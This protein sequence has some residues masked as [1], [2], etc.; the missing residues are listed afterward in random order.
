MNKLSLFLP[1]YN[2][3]QCLQENIFKLDN[4]LKTQKLKYEIFI[5]DDNSNDGSFK[6]GRKLARENQNIIYL[7]YKNGPSRRENLGLS[8]KKA[9]G[10]ILGF[11]DIHFDVS[12]TNIPRAIKYI[13]E[14][15]DFVVGSKYLKKSEYSRPAY[16]NILSKLYNYAIKKILGSPFADHNCGFKFFRQEALFKVL[17]KMGYDKS[18]KRGWFWDAEMLVRANSLGMKIYEMPVTYINN[19]NKTSVRV[20]RD[21]KAIRSMFLLRKGLK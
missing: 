21:I 15:N 13:E 18:L 14:D 7:R 6:I 11:M 10:D 5:V 8:F 19:G 4:Y 12:I 2:E 3:I 1:I 20:Y 9:S 17:D 16:R